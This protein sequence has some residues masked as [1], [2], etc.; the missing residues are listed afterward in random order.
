M[1]MK[2]QFI[3]NSI[4]F[5]LNILAWATPR[6]AAR[7][8]FALL[9]HPFRSKLSA[10]H[11][12]F[13]D[14]AQATKISYGNEVIQ[15]YRWGDGKTK[16]LFIHGWQSHSY[17]WKR[18]VETL[19][20]SAFTIYAF[21]APGHGQSSGNFLTM[22]TYSQAIEGVLCTIGSVDHIVA[23]S[24]GSFALLHRLHESPR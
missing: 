21:D 23:H 17:L 14:R 9:C 24:I 16:I 3:L 4:G 5:F 2:N 22:P 8:G 12:F 6:V 11:N 1:H 7:H 13:L 15:L 10:K 19:D 20:H 18:Y